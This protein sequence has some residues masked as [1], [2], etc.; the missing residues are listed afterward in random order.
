MDPAATFKTAVLEGDLDSVRRCL[1]DGVDPETPIDAKRG[2]REP[3]RDTSADGFRALHVAA[4]EDDA[5]LAKLLLDRGADPWART[6]FNRTP[7]DLAADWSSPAFVRAFLAAGI[8]PDAAGTRPVV[9]AAGR[10]N[11]EIVASLLAAG[12]R[13]GLGVAV[14]SAC[15]Y[16]ASPAI[17]SALLDA[18]AEP[19]PPVDPEV[20]TPRISALYSRNDECLQILAER[21]PPLTL[22]DAAIDGDLDAVAS[23]LAEGVDPNA[24]AKYG[25]SALAGAASRGNAAVV[26]RLLDAGA[27]VNHRGVLGLAIERA[28]LGGHLDVADILCERGAVFHTARYGSVFGALI[29]RGVDA[30][31]FEWVRDRDR[32]DRLGALLGRAAQGGDVIAARVLLEMGADVNGTDGW[33]RPPL[34]LAAYANRVA[35]VTFLLERGA[36]P[37]IRCHGRSLL[38]YLLVY[39]DYTDDWM[40]E[41]FDESRYDRCDPILRTEAVRLLLEAGAPLPWSDDPV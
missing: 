30:A 20:W 11:G 4:Y 21:T 3:N 29:N 2:R 8:D 22:I 15:S 38:H 32:P 31:S 35:M 14:G 34:V 24:T 28:L 13:D 25:I 6:R 5:A 10:G 39:D 33:G 41:D 23:F 26:T 1:D 9:V 27:E 37:T 7:L 36:D 19:E 16:N 40:A 18:G 17:L 12:A